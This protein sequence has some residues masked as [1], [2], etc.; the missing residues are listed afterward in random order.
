ME[1]IE[2]LALPGSLC[3]VPEGAKAANCTAGLSLYC[4]DDGGGSEPAC[5]AG[6]FA[7]LLLLRCIAQ[8]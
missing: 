8:T 1:A 2:H 4:S 6:C 3:L 7:R 5:L